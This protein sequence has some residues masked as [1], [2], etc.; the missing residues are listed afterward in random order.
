[1]AASR[2][3]P[4]AIDL[5]RRAGDRTAPRA[6]GKV[7]P[8]AFEPDR[9]LTQFDFRAEPDRA[10]QR[11]REIAILASLAIIVIGAIGALSYLLGIV[12]AAIAAAAVGALIGFGNWVLDHTIDL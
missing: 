1:M 4:E 3:Q 9:L 5:P 10:A 8:E 6:S 7:A 12:A 2:L 11:W